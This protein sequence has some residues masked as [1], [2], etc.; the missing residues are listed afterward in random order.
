MTKKVSLLI[1]NYSRELRIDVD[2]KKKGKVEKMTDFTERMKRVQEET[3]IVLRKTQEEMKQQA[4]RE[5]KEVKEWKK[6]DKV[7]LST[8]DLVLKKRLAKK[9]VDWYVG[10][11]FIDEIVST[12]MVKLQLPTLMR[13][14]PVMNISHIVW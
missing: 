6:E 4:D 1:A 7:I 2:I 8:K 14:Y 13:I 9:L 10:L 3:E 11:Y 12:N 5:K